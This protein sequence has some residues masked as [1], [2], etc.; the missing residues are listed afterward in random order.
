MSRQRRG[1][2]LLV[3]LLLVTG[4]VA[5]VVPGVPTVAAGGDCTDSTMTEESSHSCDDDTT[6]DGSDGT[7]GSDGDGSESDG[8]DGSDGD[9]SESDGTDGSDGDGSDSDDG[10]STATPTA[11]PTPVTVEG[12]PDVDV[13]LPDNTVAPGEE[14]RLTVQIANGGTVD[15]E[16]LDTPPTGQEAVTTARN[17]RVELDDGDAPVTV[18]TAETALGDLPAG[19]VAEA[20]FAIQVD[21]DADPGVYDLE[22][23]VEYDYTEEITDDDSDREFERDTF[24]VELVVTEDGRFRV[25][26]VDSDLQVGETGPVDIELRNVGEEDLRDATVTVRS[27]ND[28]LRLGGDGEATRAVGDWDDGD[29]ETVTVDATLSADAAS[30]QYPLEVTVSYTDENGDRQTSTVLVASVEPDGEQ[31]FT[32]TD[33]ESTLR[34]GEEGRVTGTVENEGPRDVE[35]AVIRVVET[36]EN[37]RVRDPVTVLGDVEEDDDADFS[38]PVSVLDTA[39]PGE[40]RVTV[41]VEYVTPAGDRRESDPID[42]IVDVS[43]ETARFELT[44]VDARLQAGDDGPLV[45]TVVNRGDETLTDATVSLASRSSGLLVGDGLNDTRFVGRWEP[46]ERRI[47]TY[48]VRAGEDTAGQTYAFEASVAFEDEDGQQR[49]SDALAFGATPVSEQTFDARTVESTLRVG[50]EGRVRVAVT[51]TGPTAVSAV[52]VTLVTEAQNVAPIETEAAV[53]ELAPGATA[54]FDLPI[55]ITEN[56]GPGTR[57]LSYRVAYT[58][59]DGDRRESDPLTTDVEIAPARDPF[60]VDD[61]SATVTAGESDVVELTL[62]NT[63]GV[64]LTDIRAKAFADDP[65]SVDDDQVFVS[66]LAPGESVTIQFT[67]SAAGGAA[68]KPYLLSVDF[69][70]T[71]PD[72][73]T[74]LSDPVNVGVGVVQPAPQQLPDWLVPVLVGFV[75][76]LVAAFL[77]R[78]R[79]GGRSSPAPR[80]DVPTTTQDGGS[81]D[82]GPA[83][84]GEVGASETAG[85]GGVD[86]PDDADDEWGA[87]ERAAVAEVDTADSQSNEGSARHDGGGP[88]DGGWGAFERA[89]VAEADGDSETAWGAFERAVVSEAHTPD[90]QSDDAST[91]HEGGDD[92]PPGT[93]G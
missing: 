77:L 66:S 38:L 3:T 33:V 9:G 64:P 74:E 75:I 32:V 30:Q 79:L 39:Q 26:D 1:R 85:D 22:V 13:F 83:A 57:Q 78:R 20:G 7:D 59:D 86:Q 4:A 88:A 87:F 82:P 50:E 46:G 93:D 54:T 92:G 67:V 47:V 28:D 91:G 25:T 49:R 80:G 81:D 34:V 24:D 76:L 53:G 55:E 6:D 70:Y 48:R 31:S 17:V 5:V 90:Q 35:A 58:D 68:E 44:A 72:G 63:R 11:T 12:E 73:D 18:N 51:N 71:T 36:D 84:T 43:S 56:A 15:D 69:L 19:S 40:R 16:G 52:G 29:R 42:L 61:R 2:V 60:A 27:P 37:V 10:E 14:R 23:T 8:T 45:L 65:L 21:E 41:V 89:T 62:T